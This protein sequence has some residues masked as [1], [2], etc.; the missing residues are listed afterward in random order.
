MPEIEE[1]STIEEPILPDEFAKLE[2][3]RL[4]LENIADITNVNQKKTLVDRELDLRRTIAWRLVTEFNYT[5]QKIAALLEVN[6]STVSRDLKHFTDDVLSNLKDVAEE[7][8]IVQVAQLKHLVQELTE[9]WEAS[10]INEQQITQST[11]EGAETTTVRVK[12]REGDR[13]YI[14]EIRNCL[15]DIR[16]ILGADAPIKTAQT[17]A[18]GEDVTPRGVIVVLPD[19]GR[20][21]TSP[22]TGATVDI[23]FDES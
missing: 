6:Q 16:K 1:Q 14:S 8:K 23:S 5:Q 10:K 21:Q 18:K 7:E 17:N 3:V 12:G 2:Q 19:N 22:T 4:A 11:K 20:G 13:A 9:A 15:Q